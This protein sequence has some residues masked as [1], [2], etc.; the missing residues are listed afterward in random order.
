MRGSHC[1]PP[2]FCDDLSPA[3]I[4]SPPP[5]FFPLCAQLDRRFG[6]SVASGSYRPTS[7]PASLPSLYFQ[8][9]TSLSPA[10]ANFFKS[11]NRGHVLSASPLLR[12]NNSRWWAFPPCSPPFDRD[13]LKRMFHPLQNPTYFAPST[14]E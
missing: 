10:A 12:G 2:F 13:H 14:R 11:S 7:F 6:L 5:S 8:I 4:I 9:T 1:F 3:N